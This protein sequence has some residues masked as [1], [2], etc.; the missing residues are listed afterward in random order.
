MSEKLPTVELLGVSITIGSEEEILE[1]IIRSLEGKRKKLSIVTPNP[2]MVV[3]AQRDPCFKQMLNQAPIALPDGM[4]VVWAAQL[5]CVPLK[6]RIT[7][8][9]MMENLCRVFSKRTEIVGFLG[10]KEGVAERAAERLKSKYPGLRIGFVGEIWDEKKLAEKEI[11]ILFVAFGFPMQEKWIYDH[12]E[13]LPVRAAMG[14]GG[15]FDY[16]SGRISRAP[17]FFQRLGF[18]WL[19]R[20]LVQPW[21]WKRQVSLLIFI[22]L[23]LKEYWM[24]RFRNRT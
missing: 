21:R 22:W 14:V 24:S 5:L 4:G 18:E 11:D 3:Y 10:G 7:G 13:H 16:T 15:A 23:V 17:L 9:D 20:L 8:V 6:R 2:E 19:Y 12:L 1:Y